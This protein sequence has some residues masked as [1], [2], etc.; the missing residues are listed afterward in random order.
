MKATLRIFISLIF[1]VFVAGALDLLTPER[2]EPVV[3]WSL[4]LFHKV[5]IPWESGPNPT[6]VI[7]AL[8]VDAILIALLIFW[9]L[10]K[11]KPQRTGP[12]TLLL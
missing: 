8:L 4:P 5:F 12:G 2:F 6:A 10:P 3:Y 9:L 7:F 11:K 1:G